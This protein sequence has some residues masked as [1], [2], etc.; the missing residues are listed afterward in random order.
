MSEHPEP[1]GLVTICITMNRADLDVLDQRRGDLEREQ[2]LV[3]AIHRDPWH[4]IDRPII[5]L[6]PPA[7]G[8]T[9]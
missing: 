4:T 1:A 5:T 6:T 8:I 9:G 3:A 7:G 2:W